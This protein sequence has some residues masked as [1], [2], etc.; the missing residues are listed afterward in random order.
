M[1]WRVARLQGGE[2]TAATTGKWRVAEVTG[3]GSQSSTPGKWRVAS[4]VAGGAA[5][6]AVKVDLTDVE[7]GR[8]VTLTATRATV[9]TAHQWRY[10]GAVDKITGAAVTLATPILTTVA[11]VCKL[12]APPSLNGVTVTMS[13]RAVDGT[14]VG[15]EI[16]TQFSVRS[17]TETLGVGRTPLVVHVAG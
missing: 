8:I 15:A 4:L 12:Q 10:A 1:A 14:T 2:A 16:F 13:Y 3:S 7:P 6:S 9:P 11:G 17:A 5:T